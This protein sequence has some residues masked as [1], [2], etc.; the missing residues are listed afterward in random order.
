MRGITTF[1][2]IIGLVLLITGCGG[3]SNAPSGT[4]GTAVTG[5]VQA[6]AGQLAKSVPTLK[7][8]FASLLTGTES[9][10][11]EV[12]NW[13]GVSGMTVRAFLIDD[14]GNP[15]GSV[16]ATAT[17]A[18]DGTFTLNVPTTQ[19]LTIN[20]IVQ[21]AGPAVT[22][23][24]AVGTPNTFSAPVVAATVNLNPA[25]EAAIRTL[26]Q[27]P[28]PLANFSNQ[29]ITE[30]LDAISM[31]VEQNPPPSGLVEAVIT[32]IAQARGLA[33]TNGLGAIGTPGVGP[34]TIL[35]TSLPNAVM[36][37]PY[38]VISVSFGV[39]PPLPISPPPIV[40]AAVGG[41]G[42]RTWSVV[43]GTLPAG[44]SLNANTGAISGTPTALG[45]FNFTVRVQDSANPAQEVT[46]DLSITVVPAPLVITTATLSA[47]TVNQVYNQTLTATGGTNPLSWSLAAGSSPLPAG[48]SLSPAGLLS[49][50]PTTVGT[51]PIT[52]QVQDAGAP[53]QTTTKQLSLTINPPGPPPPVIT[54]TSPLPVGIVGQPYS[55]T[56]GAING[57]PPYSWSLVPGSGNLPAGLSLSSTGV[58]S[59]TPTAQGTANFT[60]QVLD[61][62]SPQQSATKLF[63]LTI[64]AVSSFNYGGTLTLTNAPAAAGTTFVAGQPN[65]S[66]SQGDVHI[67]WFEQTGTVEE[68]LSLSFNQATG[69]LVS[70][71]YSF[72]DIA[73]QI[74]SAS[75]SCGNLLGF[76]TCNGVA[77]DRNAGTLTLT[78]TALQS[79]SQPSTSVTLNGTL[80]FSPITITTAILPSGI[81]GQ[82]YN[83]QLIAIGGTLPFTWSLAPGSAPLPGGLNLSTIGS[84]G[85]SFGV[86]PPGVGAIRWVGAIS[87]TP[88]TAGLFGNEDTTGDIL[89][90]VQDAA[91][92]FTD[93]DLNMIIHPAGTTSVP[94]SR[95]L[96]SPIGIMSAA[97][98]FYDGQGRLIGTDSGTTSVNF[99]VSMGRVTL[100]STDVFSAP[101][102]IVRMSRWAGP[103]Q[104][105]GLPVFNA[106]QGS[107]N[108]SGIPTAFTSLP[109]TGQTVYNVIASTHPTIVD[110]S[111]AP[112]IGVTGTV[113]V[114]W[115]SKTVSFNL[116]VNGPTGPLPFQSGSTATVASD[117]TISIFAP[118][119]GLSLNSD[120]A[121]G[122][123][124][125]TEAIPQYLGLSLS[126]SLAGNSAPIPLQVHGAVV[127]QKQ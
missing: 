25:I 55:R 19:P 67:S 72:F 82:S 70:L 64:N 8:W 124:Y 84:S 119:Q 22:G 73:N 51:T 26:I 63:S 47:G 37:R 115:M 57:T 76:P 88:T 74:V 43:N 126:L 83:Q 68:N 27:R 2:G 110:G 1:I 11:L 45:Q 104:G 39:V 114:N 123:F 48:L 28:E 17:T 15:T 101:N 102:Q 127:L 97:T 44:L 30:F 49:G 80:T 71:F 31:L 90:R 81:V 5:S 18:A 6:P 60:V 52:V 35:T 92:H 120:V 29:D 38:D 24:V 93:A 56:L 14:N 116:T 108:I 58:I 98:A 107:H 20:L 13:A 117:G 94:N 113:T 99:P 7:Q 69:A 118:M 3:E 10:A 78:N 53:Q 121:Q 95:V 103:G 87:G 100:V 75:V 105:E 125:G 40:L 16:L 59:G 77:L 61:S 111:L 122:S 34:L 85:S 86:V 33:I 62:G 96:I 4:S 91:G 9:Y 12:A 36:Q 79:F 21:I 89:F 66:V 46:K 42:A 65:Q 112:G 32:D 54:T 109:A 23:P 41:T 50:T 106:N